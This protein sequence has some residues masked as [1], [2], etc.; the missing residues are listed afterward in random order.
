MKK[1]KT[2]LWLILLFMATLSTQAQV[3]EGF[4]ETTFPPTDWAI[5]GTDWTRTTVW[6]HAGNASAKCDAHMGVE[7]LVTPKILPDATNNTFKFWVRKHTYNAAYNTAGESV[8]VK[9]STT[10]NQQA[11]FTTEIFTLTRIIFRLH[12]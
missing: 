2:A 1:M 5:Y 9:V 7:A 12:L 10:N 8:S 11:S 4:E 6:H 3:I